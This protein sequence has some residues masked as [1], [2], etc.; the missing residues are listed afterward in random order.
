MLGQQVTRQLLWDRFEVQLLARDVEQA[1]ANDAR[2]S[3]SALPSHT[4]D[5][6]KI[7]AEVKRRTLN[8][9]GR[10]LP[11]RKPLERRTGI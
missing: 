3:D 6:T 4:A 5:P 11:I 9:W 2:N 8:H 7:V 10:G 1:C